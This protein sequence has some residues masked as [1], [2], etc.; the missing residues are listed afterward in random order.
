MCLCTYW[1][2][3]HLLWLKWLI[4]YKK[5]DQWNHTIKNYNTCWIKKSNNPC[6]RTGCKLQYFK[7]SVTVALRPF[8]ESHISGITCFSLELWV[9]SASS[10]LWYSCDCFRAV[11]T[12]T[13]ASSPKSFFKDNNLGSFSS[14]TSWKN[15]KRETSNFAHASVHLWHIIESPTLQ[16]TC[17]VLQIMPV[18]L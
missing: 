7:A 6:V 16:I 10:E 13:Y 12:A 8:W 5:E 11:T 2:K 18:W 17:H 9:F 14:I 15:K 1:S 3:K 4:P